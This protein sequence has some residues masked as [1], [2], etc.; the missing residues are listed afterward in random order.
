[1]L[2]KQY[3]NIQIEKHTASFMSLASEMVTLHSLDRSHYLG[4]KER[5]SGIHGLA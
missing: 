1:M 2:Y 5:L 3:N 4:V